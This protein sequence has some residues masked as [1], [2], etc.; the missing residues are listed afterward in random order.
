[1]ESLSANRLD[2]ARGSPRGYNEAD[3]R[4]SSRGSPR[5]GGR[6]GE[7]DMSTSSNRRE[8]L[9]AATA[10]GAAIAS[11]TDL[12]FLSRLPAVSAAELKP[13]QVHF[14]PEIEPMVRLI[15]ETPR[16]RLLE[17]IADRIG[18]G[19][20]Y[21]E[22]LSGLLLA[23]I[24]NVQPRPNVGFKFHA[25]LVVNSAHLASRASAPENRW[26]PIFWA[27]DYFKEAQAQDEREGDWTM[28]AV[29]ESR[30]PSAPK[31]REALIAA[32]DDWDV[33]ATD[34]ATA[35]FVRHAK[36]TDVYELLFAYGARDFRDIGH[37]AIYVAN[38]RRTLE[39]LGWRHAEPTLRSL[40][41]ALTNHEGANPANRDAPA[42][43]PWRQ[44]L[45]R[46]K[47]FP[48]EWERG[49]PDSG[50]TQSLLASLRKDDH[51]TVCQ[52]VVEI[53]NRGVSPQSVWDALYLGAA[54]LLARQPG[55]VAL[56]AVTSTNA[57]AYA[58][59]T[60]AVEHTK[61]MLLLQ[62]AAFLT[63]FRE[64]MAGRGKVGDYR[65]DKLE[66]I[67]PSNATPE[68]LAEVFASLDRDRLTAA[69]RAA[70][71]LE[72]SRRSDEFL[73]AARLLIFLKGRNSHDYKFS[74]ALLEDYANL[75]PEYRAAYLAT[76]VYMLRGA[77][78]ADN[79]LVARTR[80]ALAKA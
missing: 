35:A 42:D 15:E 30:A 53:L 79:P 9:G 26:L 77:D 10:A 47:S 2:G 51:S 78:E 33:A 20:T 69:R 25:V 54:E 74:S 6:P 34:A 18:Q 52:S 32:L 44:N 3:D 80:A 17:V 38:S 65:V 71:F 67:R 5:E 12:G 22:V 7:T 45:E 59:R 56:H 61:R 76:G 68:A 11:L 29:D 39:H 8:F 73:E 19:T 21:D 58:Y 66:P 75:S 1:M 43:R 62:N 24:R 57:L 46:A 50:A 48:K 4:R 70:G 64:A 16:A 63:L 27:L 23:G 36:P 14:S 60:T 37:K 28:G 31:A 72:E 13:S 40:T 49:H 55:I 41:Y